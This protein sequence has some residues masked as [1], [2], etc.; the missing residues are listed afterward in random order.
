MVQPKKEKAIQVVLEGSKNQ[1]KCLALVTICP[2]VNRHMPL[3]LSQIC[4]P[5]IALLF[6]NMYLEFNA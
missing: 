5:D 6:E 1:F 2:E 3:S 4:Q